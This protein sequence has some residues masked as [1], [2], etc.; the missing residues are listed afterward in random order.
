MLAKLA[1][2][3]PLFRNRFNLNL[4]FLILGVK[5]FILGLKLLAPG[6]GFSIALLPQVAVL[7]KV[8]ES[9]F[10]QLELILDLLAF[11][12]PRIAARFEE[13][14]QFSQ[15]TSEFWAWFKTWHF[16]V[17]ASVRSAHG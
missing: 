11:H 8:F 5:M 6:L 1:G 14:D 15:K 12:L 4:K 7:L 10:K 9:T 13:H 3:G 17:T 2:D 16:R